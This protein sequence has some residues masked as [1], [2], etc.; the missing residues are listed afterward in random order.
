M[1]SEAYPDMA[2][3]AFQLMTTFPNKVIDD[4]SVDLKEAGLLNAV[5]VVKLCT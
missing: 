1:V 2:A 5:V 4:E 3:T